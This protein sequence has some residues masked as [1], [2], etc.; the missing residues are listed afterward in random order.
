MELNHATIRPNTRPSISFISAREAKLSGDKWAYQV[1]PH[2]VQCARCRQWINL[3]KK[4]RFNLQNWYK[5]K[6]CCSHITGVEPGDITQ[7]QPPPDSNL[8]WEEQNWTKQEQL[9]LDHALSGWARWIVDYGRQ[10]VKS[11]WC[12]GTTMNAS[13][14]CNACQALQEDD[15]FKRAVARQKNKEAQLSE[16]KQRDIIVHREKYAPTTL[17]TAEARDL[18]L[19]MSDTTIFKLVQAL[20]RGDSIRAFLALYQCAKEG[21]LTRYQTFVDICAVLEKQLSL[22]ES[23]SPGAKKGI[24]YPQD[25]LNFMTIM[26]SY[27]QHSAQQYGILTSQI[28]GPCPRSHS[29]GVRLKV[30]KRSPD[31]LSQPDLDFENVARVKRLMDSLRYCGPVARLSYSNDHGSHIL[32]S[33]LSLDDCV[34]DEVDDITRIVAH[35]RSEKKFASQVR[36]ILVKIPLPQVPPLV[37]ALRP[38]KGNDDAASI[39]ALHVRLLDMAE[40]LGIKIIS[41]YPLYSISLHAP[42]FPTGPLTCWNQPQHG[43]HTASLGRGFVVNRCLINVDKQDDGTARQLFHYTAL[44]AMTSQDASG[45]TYV[46]DEFLGLFV[47]LFIFVHRNFFGLARTLLP[48]FTYAELLKLILLSGKVTAKKER[49]ACAG[50]VLDYDPTP[51]TAAELEHAR[52]RLPEE[53]VNRLVEVAH[54]EATQIAKQLLRL[55]I[56]ALPFSQIPLRPPPM[57]TR[58]HLASKAAPAS[59]DSDEEDDDD[60]HV[61]DD[62]DDDDDDEELDGDLREEGGLG[63]TEFGAS[64]SAIS[65][66]QADGLDDP[67]LMAQL[68]KRTAEAVHYTARLSALSEDLDST[69]NELTEEELACLQQPGK[70]GPLAHPLPSPLLAGLQTVMNSSPLVFASKILDNNDK[71][72]IWQML[73]LRRE[74]QSSTSTHS[75]R[76]VK[77]DPKFALSR[78][79]HPDK[80]MSIREASHVL[81]VAQDLAGPPVDR[82]KSTRERHWQ[83]VAR[84]VQE[85]VKEQGLILYYTII[86]YACSQICVIQICQTFRART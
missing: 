80:K 40:Q 49:T 17:R 83:E 5:H 3:H 1:E 50:Y 68:A 63:E 79:E 29:T 48:D 74:H 26:R 73:D 52:V 6:Q 10:L 12:E 35:V 53:S 13:G 81:R 28:G 54:K 21:K 45:C 39:Y 65:S 15:A 86:H 51:L 71:I 70:P 25:Y 58:S 82:L 61:N 30:V 85:V 37:I 72:V 67:A 66:V 75:E 20:E 19:K 56:P 57:L 31:V 42:V 18:Q 11:T 4:Q 76:V 34:V 23:D 38:T 7:T 32:G 59:E 41:L 24:R 60:V 62:D 8:E 16:D 33:T 44:E 9:A 55:P 36:A 78:L 22:A 84:N 69:V 14:V 43:T 47:Y 77:V 27:G 46:Q 64:A 2:R